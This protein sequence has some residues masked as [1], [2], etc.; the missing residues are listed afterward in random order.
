MNKVPA[1]FAV[2]P[3][4]NSGHQIT[5]TRDFTSDPTSQNDLEKNAFLDPR[6]AS[7]GDLHRVSGDLRLAPTLAV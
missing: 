4:L 2:H 6:V 1:K 5:K 3:F 7:K